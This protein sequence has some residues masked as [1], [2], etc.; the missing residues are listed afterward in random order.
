MT[1]DYEFCN[2]VCVFSHLIKFLQKRTW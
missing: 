2:Y 1:Q